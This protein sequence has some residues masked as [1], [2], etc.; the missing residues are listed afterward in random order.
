MSTEI[1]KAVVRR[2]IDEGYSQGK[3]VAFDELVASECVEHNP[4]FGDAYGP[5]GARQ[6]HMILR[7]AFPDVHFT[8][9]D[10]IAERDRVV[11][12]W[13]FQGTQRGNLLDV[14]PTGRSV[15]SAGIFVF[16]LAAERIV[17]RWESIDALGVLQQ[18]G[19]IPARE[20]AEG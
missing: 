13:T 11:A 18:L 7:N 16:R 1:N 20:R 5:E 4:L 15:T 9:E 3:R 6:I 17:E 19:A 8:V 12:R 10:L 2:I 14:P